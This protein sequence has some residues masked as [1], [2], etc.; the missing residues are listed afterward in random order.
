MI[1]GLFWTIQIYQVI[2][3]HIYGGKKVFTLDT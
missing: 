2:W 1:Q 3:Y